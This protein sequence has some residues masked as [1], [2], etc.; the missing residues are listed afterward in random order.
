MQAKW[1]EMFG[2]KEEVAE[3]KVK[4]LVKKR[5]ANKA[6]EKNTA[7]KKKNTG[8]KGRKKVG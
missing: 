3:E 5:T 7:T 6:G 2:V 4:K 8:Q 1:D